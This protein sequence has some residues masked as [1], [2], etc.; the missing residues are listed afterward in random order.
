MLED[1]VV[2]SC[3]DKYDKTG[4]VSVEDAA[5]SRLLKKKNIVKKKRE[6]RMG[7]G[8]DLFKGLV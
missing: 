5:Y 4:N 7:W 2:L 1:S 3:K 8:K 6:N